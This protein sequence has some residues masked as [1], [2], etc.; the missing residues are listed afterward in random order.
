VG[1]WRG[2]FARRGFDGLH[3]KPRLGKPRSIGDEDVERVIVK[4]LEEQPPK[5]T[6]TTTCGTALPTST[7]HWTSPWAKSSPLAAAVRHNQIAGTW[8]R[9]LI[10][11]DH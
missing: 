2:R 4:T 5:A 1:R 7:P 11:Y 8:D 10:A 9:S 3:D 6:P